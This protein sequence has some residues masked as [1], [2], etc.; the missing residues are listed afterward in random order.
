MLWNDA[1]VICVLTSWYVTTPFC[2][3]IHCGNTVERA[4]HYNHN[5]NWF[6]RVAARIALYT[7]THL[8]AGYIF[9]EL[10][11][12]T[13][14]TKLHLCSIWTV[15]WSQLSVLTQVIPVLL[16]Y[17][18]VGMHIFTLGRPNMIGFHD[19]YICSCHSVPCTVHSKS[20]IHKQCCFKIMC[21]VV[22]N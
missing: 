11:L 8:F 3:N 13:R 20:C 9:T 14:A 4:P 2:I 18:W 16:I 21:F 12:T 17:V 7:I 6:R 10:A 19:E 15:L 22:V 1:D 5:R